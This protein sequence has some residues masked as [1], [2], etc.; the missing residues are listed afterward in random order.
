MTTKSEKKPV[1]RQSDAYFEL[2]RQFP[3]VSIKSERQLKSAQRVIDRL[4]AQ[5]LTP[6]A[7]QYLDA[8]SDL[9]ATYEDAHHAIAAPSDADLLAH[10]LE[11]KGISQAQLCRETKLA[12]STVSAVLSGK[13]TFTKDMVAKLSDYF[14]I[15]RG[16]LVANF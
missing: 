4:L 7:A 10:L 3:L 2:V 11:T 14:Q 5:E 15:D 16:V 6:G 12:A 8:L 9:V 1:A 13:R